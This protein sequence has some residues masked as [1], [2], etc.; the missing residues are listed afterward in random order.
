M[1]ASDTNPKFGSACSLRDRPSTTWTSSEASSWLALR[2]GVLRRAA[3]SSGAALSR[4]APE[5]RRG[6]DAPAVR[7]ASAS[8]S[9]ASRPWRNAAFPVGCSAGHTVA[10]APGCSA[11]RR[12]TVAPNPVL[13]AH[14]R[15]ADG[16][17][18]CLGVQW[19]QR[20]TA[21]RPALLANHSLNRTSCKQAAG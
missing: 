19:L 10:R 18:F 1:S 14:T 2:A 7:V 3:S 11:L 9:S 21:Q 8:L 5:G 6:N 17:K 16:A 4:C 15:K 20:L 13:G 12:Q